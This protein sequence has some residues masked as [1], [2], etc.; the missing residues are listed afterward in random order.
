MMRTNLLRRLVAASALVMSALLLAPGTSAA[1]TGQANTTAAAKTNT[2]ADTRW[3]PWLGCWT[4]A[5]PPAAT[6]GS[7][8]QQVADSLTMSRKNLPEATG[9]HV[10][11]IPGNGPSAVDIWTISDGKLGSREHIEASGEHRRTERDGCTGWESAQ[12]SPDARRVYLQSEYDCVG[13]P[14][15]SSSGLIAMTPK[16]EWLNIVG[17]TMGANTGVRVARHRVAGVTSAMPTDVVA[18]LRAS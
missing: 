1:Q 18:A 6:F 3:Q 11:V 13:S 17:V 8:P 4:A 14:K 5:L 2:A 12:W 15:R 16:G 10:C 7:T 9:Q